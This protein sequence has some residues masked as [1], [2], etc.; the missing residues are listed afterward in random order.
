MNA[1]DIPFDPASAFLGDGLSLDE[2]DAGDDDEDIEPRAWLFG[3]L[4]CRGFLSG[5][6]GEGGVGKTALRL[7]QLVSMASGQSLTG[8]HVFRRSR[9]L[10]VC[11][12]DDR[13]EARRRLKAA[14]LH[15]GIEREELRGWLFFA[16][17]RGVKLADL[18]DKAPSVGPLEAMVRQTIERRRIDVV[19]FDPFIKAH[20]LPEND[21]T[22]IDFVATLLA[23]MA[24]EMKVATDV[25][26]HTRKGAAMAGDAEAGRG[27]GSLKDAGRLVYTLTRMTPEEAQQFG[28][29]ERDRLLYGRFDS[30]K[31]NLAPPSISARWFKLVGVKLNNG[32]PE[33]PAGDEV[34]TVE[35]WTPPDTWAGLGHA[36][37]NEILSVIDRGM[38]NGRRYS[39]APAA[40]DTAAWRVVVEH[41]A[42]KTEGQAREIINTWIK[43]GTLVAVD[44]KDP[45]RHETAKGLTVNNA[46]RPS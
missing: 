12:E 30:A 38:P 42:D 11:L 17:P 5:L 1:N 35:V 21:N 31:V 19:S 29:G 25:T 2:W 6:I 32:T 44:Y 14:M 40:R 15:H 36:I 26:H 27:A 41:A 45:V 10:I 24:S 7:L 34:Q 22:S 13:D 8:D 18:I 37:L 16:T 28:I 46:K 20:S 9:V 4:F 3:N 23:R 33:Y 43:N 39:A